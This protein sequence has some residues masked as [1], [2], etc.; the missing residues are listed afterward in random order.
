MAAQ[1]WG[2]PRHPNAASVAFSPLARG[3]GSW[4][5]PAWCEGAG[6]GTGR[7]GDNAHHSSGRASPALV[8]AFWGG[9]VGFSS[10]QRNPEWGNARCVWQMRWEVLRGWCQ[11]GHCVLAGRLTLHRPVAS[12]HHPPSRAW[13]GKVTQPPAQM[14]SYFALN[15][16]LSL[17]SR[18]QFH[19]FSPVF[20]PLLC[21]VACS[22][23]M[24]GFLST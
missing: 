13:F 17:C 23:P 21:C 7:T 16:L 1:V 2:V 9:I 8:S 6:A 4:V 3:A 10:C 22:H 5:F 12:A 19:S 20:P 11:Q 14:S 15:Y 24:R 18:S